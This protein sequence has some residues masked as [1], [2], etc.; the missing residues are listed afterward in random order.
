[1]L[2]SGLSQPGLLAGIFNYDK[3]ALCVSEGD[4]PSLGVQ[5]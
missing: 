2:L 5:F 4:G 3:Q 1:M